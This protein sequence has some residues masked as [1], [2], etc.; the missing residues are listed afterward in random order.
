MKRY[1]A[2]AAVPFLLSCGRESI[3]LSDKVSAP[4]P[5]GAVVAPIKIA[6]ANPRNYCDGP[7]DINHLFDAYTNLKGTITERSLSIPSIKRMYDSSKRKYQK[8]RELHNTCKSEFDFM[9]A[10]Y[11]AVESI[12]YM[13]EA[14]ARQKEVQSTGKQ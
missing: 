4:S 11:V 13:T 2:I 10:S 3:D 12:Q 8:A 6:T 7:S 5:Q 1:L 9:L 14:V